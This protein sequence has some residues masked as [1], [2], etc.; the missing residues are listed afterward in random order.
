MIT[1]QDEELLTELM[2]AHNKCK[3]CHGSD[4]NCESYK[5]VRLEMDKI[6][7]NIPTHY[8]HMSF[9][10]IDEPKLKK[11][12]KDVKDYI[13]LAK[14][15][16]NSGKGLYLHGASGTAK[17]SV[18]CITLMELMKKGH[19]AYYTD[20]NYYLESQ[21]A[22]NDDDDDLYDLLREQDF[23]L[24]DNMGR[25]Y[26]DSKGFKKSKIEELIRFRADHRMPIIMISNLSQDDL[27]K[28]N[29]SVRSLLKEHFLKPILF[30]CQDYRDKIRQAG[31]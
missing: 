12:I 24:L 17:T 5:P 31:K 20:L 7:Y 30:N 2:A 11:A 15:Y 13:D 10:D 25:E 23:V 3:I 28:T 4:T 21:F 14:F 27:M 22:S 9:N 26:Q 1:K 6:T 18:G 8:R 16:R 29:A 19:S